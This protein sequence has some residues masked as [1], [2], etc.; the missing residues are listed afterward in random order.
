MQAV[1]L[2]Y[3]DAVIPIFSTNITPGSAYLF[4]ETTA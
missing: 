2:V 1:L 3:V 4:D